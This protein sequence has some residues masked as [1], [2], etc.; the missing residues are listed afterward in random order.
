MANGLGYLS[1]LLSLA[2]SGWLS[3]LLGTL[4]FFNALKFNL[5]IRMLIGIL[6]TI[7]I[8]FPVSNVEP[9]STTIGERI[10]SLSNTDSDGSLIARKEAFNTLLGEAMV[11]FVGFGLQSPIVTD[12][13][14]K[15]SFVI[16]D[17]GILVILFALG[18]MGA[19]PYLLSLVHSIFQI[20]RACLKNNDLLLHATY[21]IILGTMSQIFF[22]SLFYG[23]FAMILWGFIGMG[24]SARNYYSNS[25]LSEI[26]VG[27]AREERFSSLS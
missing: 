21:A 22:K 2:R 7:L 11:Q 17:N 18:W 14:I 13:K 8:I 5:K 4:V 12:A 27:K 15:S 24:M 3:W 23:S 6:M 19:L 25:P 1:F 16:G 9:F 26:R 20:Q 10:E